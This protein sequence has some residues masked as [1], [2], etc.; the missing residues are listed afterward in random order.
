VKNRS[1]T[2]IA[3]GELKDANTSGVIIAQAGR[4][5][6]NNRRLIFFGGLT[7]PNN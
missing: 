1:Y 3:P 2:I 4:S 6:G 5:G 7:Q